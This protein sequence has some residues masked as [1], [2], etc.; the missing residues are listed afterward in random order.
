[1]PLQNHVLQKFNYIYILLLLYK[2]T[3]GKRR[4]IL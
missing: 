4:K 3:N 1:M 2:K